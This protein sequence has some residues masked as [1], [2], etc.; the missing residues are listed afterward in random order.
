M[1]L[2]L[3]YMKRLDKERQIHHD[4]SDV[5]NLKNMSSIHTHTHTHTHM[6]THIERDRDRERQRKSRTVTGLLKEELWGVSVEED[7]HDWT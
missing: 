4:L 6:H 3:W 1:N 5:W 2:T 7:K